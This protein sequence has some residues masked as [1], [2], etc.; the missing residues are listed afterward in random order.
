M[1]VRSAPEPGTLSAWRACSRAT[2][3]WGSETPI[4]L[5]T[6]LSSRGRL[7]PMGGWPTAVAERLWPG[8]W[9][10]ELPSL[11]LRVEAPAVL[12][13]RCEEVRGGGMGPPGLGPALEF[14]AAAAAAAALWCADGGCARGVLGELLDAPVEGRRARGDCW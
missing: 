4:L 14:M 11:A 3:S 2:S 13:E 12:L 7:V 10:L 5:M 9:R 8:C 1:G 6:V